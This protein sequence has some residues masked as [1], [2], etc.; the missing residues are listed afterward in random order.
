M[1]AFE[2]RH[3]WFFLIFLF[4]VAVGLANLAHYLLFRF[5]RLK[6]S[7]SNVRIAMRKHLSKPVRVISILVC[8]MIVVPLVPKL[9]V[10]VRHLVEHLLVM[11]LVVSLGWLI[12]GSVYVVEAIILRR[13]DMSAG[14]IE[15]R[16]MHTRF[17]VV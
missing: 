16:T 14:D 2:E 7:E 5:T 11:A 9:P 15:A 1:S 13:Y 4:C 12:A 17:G 10:Q 6:K 3:A 8:V